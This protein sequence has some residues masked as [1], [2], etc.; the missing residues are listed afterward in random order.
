VVNSSAVKRKQS[1]TKTSPSKL[2]KKSDSS[3]V[4]DLVKDFATVDSS[5]KKEVIE[6]DLL[7]VEKLEKKEVIES[8]LLSVEKLEKKEVSNHVG[9]KKKSAPAKKSLKKRKKNGQKKSFADNNHFDIDPRLGGS[10]IKQT[11]S[12]KKKDKKSKSIDNEPKRNKVFEQRFPY[13]HVEGT[14]TS[15]SVVKIINGHVK[16][17]ENEGKIIPKVTKAAQ[18]VDDEHR[19][20]AAKVGFTSTLSDKYDTHNHDISW[21]C[22]FCQQY[23]HMQCLGDLYGPYYINEVRPEPIWFSK[24]NPDSNQSL[25]DLK[26]MEALAAKPGSK[27]SKKSP[28][29][30]CTPKIELEDSSSIVSPSTLNQSIVAP[31]DIA[32]QSNEKKEV[33][34]HESCLIWAPGVCLVP[35][36]LVGL[37]EAISDSQ[38][39]VCDHCQKR[40]GH[41]FCRRR[42][43]GLRTHYPCAVANQW[44]LEEEEFLALCP[45]HQNQHVN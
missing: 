7:S 31:T 36:R 33:W 11:L 34:F 32:E 23:T 14:W 3:I 28:K 10:K 21:V 17:D 44:L 20:R 37:D 35:P 6:S 8:D 25:K 30:K 38:Q 19:S 12:S 4:C 13:I 41:I 43:C 16:E 1:P 29:K 9:K 2:E 27:K 42:G 40:G 24:K 26:E 15:P 5:V 22:T 18:Y 39:V 45:A